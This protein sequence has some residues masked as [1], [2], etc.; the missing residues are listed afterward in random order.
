MAV[1]ISAYNHTKKKLI[2]SEFDL[3]NLKVMLRSSTT[4]TAADTVVSDLNGSEVSGNGWTAGGE[5]IANAAVTIVDTDDAMLDGDDVRVTA[6]GGDIG[7]TDG[8]VIIDDTDGDPEL[9]AF[10]DPDGSKT[11][12]TGTEFQVNWNANGI[13]RI[14]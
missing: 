12:G 14:T 5:A 6:T 8:Y 9:V 13:L 11:A 4:F 3:T 1:T 10:V 7:P 2:N